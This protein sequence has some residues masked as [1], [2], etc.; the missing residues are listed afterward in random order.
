MPVVFL[1]LAERNGVLLLLRWYGMGGQGAHDHDHPDDYP[2][3]LI[4]CLV[5]LSYPAV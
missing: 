1:Y 2:A 3:V 5:L 4:N